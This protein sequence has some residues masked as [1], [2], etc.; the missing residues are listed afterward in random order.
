VYF[1]CLEALQ[2]AAKH[3]RDATLITISLAQD[4]GL[5]FEVRD[6]CAGFDPVGSSAGAGLANMRDRIAALGGEVTVA[7]RPGEGVAVRG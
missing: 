6:D 2:N 5:R 3:A 7:S 4:D 1:C